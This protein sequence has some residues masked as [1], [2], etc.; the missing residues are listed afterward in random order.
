MTSLFPSLSAQKTAKSVR[1]KIEKSEIEWNN[2]DG[3]W[4]T[5]YLKLNE[6]NMDEKDLDGIRYLLPKRKSK[7]GREP[8]FGSYKIENKY[9]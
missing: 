6:K 1:A 3:K 8:S 7:M 9:V 5:L 4:L 2:I